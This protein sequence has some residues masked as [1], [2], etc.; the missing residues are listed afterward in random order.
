MPN[1]QDPVDPGPQPGQQAE[2]PY[3]P[4]AIE[5]LDTTDGP[6]VTAAGAVGQITVTTTQT[7]A[8]K[9]L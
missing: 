4:P 6:S 7:A 2:G 3:E 8:P 1:R 9:E 5:D